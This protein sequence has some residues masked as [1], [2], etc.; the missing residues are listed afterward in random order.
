MSIDSLQTQES[1]INKATRG[2]TAKKQAR[3]AEA[4]LLEVGSTAK[5][6]IFLDVEGCYDCHTVITAFHIEENLIS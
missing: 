5:T 6:V 3:G 4:M 1:V 2:S